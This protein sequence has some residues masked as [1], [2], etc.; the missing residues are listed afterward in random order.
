MFYVVTL[1]NME[2]D[3]FYCASLTFYE[4]RDTT[5]AHEQT[6]IND[7]IERQSVSSQPSS[8]D[9]SKPSSSEV[10]VRGSLILDTNS[11]PETIGN[12]YLPKA[13]CIVSRLALFESFRVRSLNF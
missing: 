9:L 10:D 11:L 2:G 1:T 5:N 7:G 4:L 6:P 13:I 12:I 8:T 3:R